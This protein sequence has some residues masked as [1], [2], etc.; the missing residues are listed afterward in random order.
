ML[1]RENQQLRIVIKKKEEA[2]AEMQI[3]QGSDS[4]K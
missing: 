2:E 1:K 3:S 4:E